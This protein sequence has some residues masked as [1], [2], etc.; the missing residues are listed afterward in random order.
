MKRVRGMS[1]IDTRLIVMIGQGFL[2]QNLFIYIYREG[3][4]D[5]KKDLHT[6]V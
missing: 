3:K 4:G 6:N 5:R 1:G 2:K